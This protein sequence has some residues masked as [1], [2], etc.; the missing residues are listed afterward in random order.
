MQLVSSRADLEGD[1]CGLTWR[2]MAAIMWK[3]W[4]E[5][6]FSGRIVHNSG[7]KIFQAILSHI[8]TSHNPDILFYLLNKAWKENISY[9]EQKG[10]IKK[11]KFSSPG[12]LQITSRRCSVPQVAILQRMKTRKSQRLRL[13]L[14]VRVGKGGG[15]EGVGILTD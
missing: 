4:E 12:F 13:L 3:E 7:F 10:L 9:A 11:T 1:F 14:T 5:Q 8:D 15:A 6:T 2:T